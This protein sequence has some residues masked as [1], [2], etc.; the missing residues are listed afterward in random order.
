[1]RATAFAGLGLAAV[2]TV[3]AAA[4]TGS[5]GPFAG[6]LRQGETKTY[7]YDNNPTREQ[8]VTLATAYSVGLTYAPPSDTLTI[9]ANG[10]TRTATGGGTTISFVSG[11]CTSFTIT[12]TG[13]SVGTVAPFAVTVSRGAAVS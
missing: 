3:P 9:T 13:T 10:I 7:V 8:C 2:L 12:V 11:F 6:V 5:P 4:V 1:M